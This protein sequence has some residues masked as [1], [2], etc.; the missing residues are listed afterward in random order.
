MKQSIW[1]WSVELLVFK[2]VKK[3]IFH[4]VNWFPLF[5]CF[6]TF[7]T[8]FYLMNSFLFFNFRLCFFIFPF[9][10]LL[11]L[12][13]SFYFVVCFSSYVYFHF[14]LDRIERREK[15][16]HFC[17]FRF[18]LLIFL[19]S[20]LIFNFLFFF[21]RFSLFLEI[22]I[23]RFFFFLLFTIACFLQFLKNKT[24]FSLIFW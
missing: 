3:V 6:F 12:W 4:F 19:F 18:S 21:F 24:N 7:W 5:Y 22:L 9:S 13:F 17:S 15:M 11:F 1:R 10:I 2:S 8:D 23:F 20:C 14:G 16:I